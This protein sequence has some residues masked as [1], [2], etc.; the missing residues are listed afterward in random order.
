MFEPTYYSCALG[1]D[2]L[3]ELTADQAPWASPGP[4]NLE[5]SAV[6]FELLVHVGGDFHKMQASFLNLLL[7]PGSVVLKPGE[8]G[9]LVLGVAI[10]GAQAYRSEVSPGH[11]AQ[12]GSRQLSR[13][14]PSRTAP[15]GPRAP[16]TCG[17]ADVGF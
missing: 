1:A 7:C 5:L 2:R 15:R 14:P 9:K 16:C 4:E 8:V 3:A 6:A 13:A 11:W 12:V 10:Y 17:P